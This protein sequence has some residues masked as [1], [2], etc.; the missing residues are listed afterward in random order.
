MR[1]ALPRRSAPRPAFPGEVRLRFDAS[2]EPVVLGK[3]M[4]VPSMVT[5]R[6]T[7][8]DVETGTEG[9]RF[10]AGGP[11]RFAPVAWKGRVFVVSD[12]G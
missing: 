6:V 10:F 4:Y 8:L 12:D 9:W 7:A 2:Y 11:I 5:A 1:P 3:T